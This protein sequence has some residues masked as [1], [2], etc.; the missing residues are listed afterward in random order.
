MKMEKSTLNGE[1]SAPHQL[2]V[3][4]LVLGGIAAAVAAAVLLGGCASVDPT[5]P[6]HFVDVQ[7]RNDLSSP[8]QLIQCD[9]SCDTLHDRQTVA[10][11]DST[12]INVSNE[13]IKV[14][15]LIESL[16]GNRLGCIY[17]EYEHVKHPPAVAV[18]SKVRCD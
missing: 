11:G 4:T 13:G 6:S 17:M 5:D 18:S 3:R 10:A 7:V 15:Y 12:T 14:G 2:G 9:T 8:V 1:Q 16:T